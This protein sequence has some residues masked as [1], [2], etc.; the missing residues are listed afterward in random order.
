MLNDIKTFLSCNLFYK[1]S[2]PANYYGLNLAHPFVDNI[3]VQKSLQIKHKFKYYQNITKYIL[4]N[5]VYQKIPQS[6]LNQK[7]NGFGIPLEKYLY[8]IFYNDIIK[9]SNYEILKKQNLFDKQ[10]LKLL[11]KLQN[12]SLDRRECNIIF[13][14]YIF[15]LWYQEYIEDLWRDKT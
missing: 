7:K 9:F 14:Y 2:N 8:N 13:A 6:Y 15:Q 12:K 10:F 11:K 3:V 5:I 1:V 4:K